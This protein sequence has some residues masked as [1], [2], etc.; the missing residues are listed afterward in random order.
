MQF[1]IMY[2]TNQR[3]GKERVHLQDRFRLYQV[4]QGR[5]KG[6]GEAI[7]RHKEVAVRIIIS[8]DYQVAMLFE[9]VGRRIGCGVGL[10]C[11]CVTCE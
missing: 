7:A 11:Y 2:N 10:C 9:I 8:A 5:L 1:K 6:T 3:L 4:V